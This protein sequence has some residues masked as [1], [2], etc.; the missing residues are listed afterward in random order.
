MLIFEEYFQDNRHNWLTKDSNE[1]SLCLEA[2]Y[3][4]FE[5]K[6]PGNGSWLTWQSADFFY[7]KPEFHIHVVLEKVTGVLNHGYGFIW[8]LADNK[9]FFEFVITD[10]GY[11]QI[12]QHENGSFKEHIAWKRC[13]EIR[14]TNTMNVLEIRRD[15]KN[16]EFYIN[17]F[18]V[19]KLCAD[20]MTQVSGQKFG[21]IIYDN[22]KIKVH[23]LVISGS[24]VES[25]RLGN[26]DDATKSSFVQHEPPVDDTLEKVFADLKSLVGLEQTKQQ[27]FSLANFLKV[28]T[29]RK[30]RGLKTVD[31]SLHLVL[32]GP[33]GTGKTTIARLVGRL[34]KQLGRLQHGH[35]VE[36]DRAG[37]V[38]GYIGQTALRVADAV[39]Q[40]LEGVL[41]IDEA[42]AL[43]PKDG[44]SSDFGHEAVQALLKRMEDHRDQLAVIVAGYPE[45]MEY[46]M[47]SNPGL[48]SRF[49]RL[50]YFDDYTPNELVLIF[51]KFCYDYGYT[52]DISARIA[53]QR[54]FEN[55][56]AHRDKNFGNGRFARTM[57]ELT[58]EKQAN[59]IANCL[60]QMDDLAISLIKAEDLVVSD[61]TGS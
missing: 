33:P 56:Y 7:D 55:A 58:I 41:F 13:Y 20:T 32:S 31:T 4:I 50:F 28:Q 23:S 29:E 45:E 18:L 52:L 8:G 61:L 2:N 44:S 14:R 30:T 54:I 1:C 19:E 9:N 15:G 57:F 25:T 37:I 42:Y 40:S 3:Y 46:F 51:G 53:V 10:S 12:A 21:F 38:G 35:V 60:E 47:T 11:Y 6:R 16:I 24:S 39:K 27:L 43:V 26:S 22:T 48:Q 59:R 49:S 5:H 34:Y 17:S 36:T